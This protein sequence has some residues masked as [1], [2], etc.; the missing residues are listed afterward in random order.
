METNV[1][2]ALKRRHM[3]RSI[4]LRETLQE[5]EKVRI[6]G[7]IDLYGILRLE[8]SADKSRVKKQYKK[9]AVLLHPDKNKSV[10]AD[11]AFK[12]VSDAWTVLSDHVK[13]SM[14]D[15]RRNISALHA[16]GNGSYINYSKPPVSSHHRLDTFWTVQLLSCSI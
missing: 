3:P 9:M 8:P 16:P 2:E 14:Y 13:R 5:R 1:P 11:G 7:E 15:Q 6:N 4:L 12:Y 10:G